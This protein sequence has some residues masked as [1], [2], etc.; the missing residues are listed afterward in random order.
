MVAEC[1]TFPA[2]TAAAAPVPDA[3]LAAVRATAGALTIPLPGVD[4]ALLPAAF[5]DG[6]PSPADVLVE[7]RGVFVVAEPPTALVVT[8]WPAAV[9]IGPT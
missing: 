1:E 5:A 9:G 8:P 2:P 3:P 4:A 7:S 6:F